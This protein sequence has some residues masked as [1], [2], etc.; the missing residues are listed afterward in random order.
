MQDVSQD[1]LSLRQE[2]DLYRNLL[3]LG[4]KDEIEPF[5][6]EALALIVESS[7]AR[8]GY[9]EILETHGN[10]NTPRL[11]M[12]HGCYDADVE[13]IRDR[14]S[15]GVLG[16]A[17]ASGQTVV[18]ASALEDPR[19]ADR[20]SVQ[21][22][23]TG[24]VLC[25]PIGHPPLGVVYLQDRIG[26]GPFSEEDRSRVERFTHYLATF[27]D[28]LLLRRQQL[29]PDPTLDVRQRLRTES[30]IGRS[31]AIAR[32]LEQVA[33]AASCDISVL[34]TGPSGTGKTQVAR[35]IHDNSTRARRPFVELNCA[36]LQETLAERELFGAVRGAFSGADKL[37]KGKIDA[38]EG[39]TLFL[40]EIGELPLG[41]QAKL[42]QF[43]QSRQ[44]FRV[45]GTEPLVADVRVVAATNN[46][47]KAA[48]A[49][50]TF[51]DD[52]RYRLE[53]LPIVMPSLEERREDIPTLAEH[54]CAKA[55]ESQ[56]RARLRLSPGALLALQV[57]AWE[58]NVRELANKIEAAVARAGVE[59]APQ[60]D[61]RHIFPESSSEPDK[62][63][64][65]S[66][67][68]ATRQFQKQLLARTL[69]ESRWNISEAADR[70]ELSRA[71]VYNLI[72]GFGLERDEEE[73]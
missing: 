36:N 73:E 15:R 19:F 41:V 60:V 4:G 6:E 61:R 28:R 68:E 11:W 40:D 65:L 27:A 31:P 43:L 52:L 35:L 25:S 56:K 39:G 30:V 12:A 8:Q 50:R 55:C 3:E 42:L 33:V 54:F 38:A 46:D 16:A 70:M 64:S 26:P 20:R 51:R 48:V 59:G 10:A 14:V 37:M 47:L 7:S 58:G 1:V 29:G 44:Y 22:N 71:H 62:P 57:V 24:A 2:R 21:R 34:I 17:V 32:V 45:G 66:Y 18:S 53:V 69:K 9:L 63:R 13:A 49:R 23:R 72:A 67:H 5:L